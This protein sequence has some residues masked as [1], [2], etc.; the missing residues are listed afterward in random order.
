L[1]RG[2]LETLPSRS[3]PYLKELVACHRAWRRYQIVLHGVDARRPRGF[4]SARDG[5]NPD[6]ASTN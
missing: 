3:H 6:A 2:R 5:M 4:G 1:P